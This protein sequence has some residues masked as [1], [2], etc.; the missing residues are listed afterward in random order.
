MSNEDFLFSVKNK[1]IGTEPSSLNEKEIFRYFNAHNDNPDPV[2]FIGDP[3][4]FVKIFHL[5]PAQ[6]VSY[7]GH[8]GERQRG[9]LRWKKFMPVYG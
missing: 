1:V 5:P 8:G 3:L 4:S 6:M 2:E 9:G 7:E